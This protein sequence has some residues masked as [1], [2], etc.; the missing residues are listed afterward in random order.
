MNPFSPLTT[1]LPLPSTVTPALSQS[2]VQPVDPRA[3]RSAITTDSRVTYAPFFPSRVANPG[4]PGSSPRSGVS[5]R[6]TS[7]ADQKRALPREVI[8]RTK[9]ACVT[10][11]SGWLRLCSPRGRAKQI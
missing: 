6:G 10:Q 2:E 11:H 3:T 8:N 5:Q 1:M 4:G 9:G 7:P